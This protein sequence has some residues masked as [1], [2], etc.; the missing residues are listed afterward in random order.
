MKAK[1][2][3]TYVVIDV[4]IES[5]GRD[6]SP[7]NPLYFKVRDGDGYEYTGSLIGADNG[8]KSGELAQGERVR[9]TVSFDV[10]SEAKGLVVSYQPLVL[11]GGYQVIRVQLE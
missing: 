6:K 10:P 9:G 5:P 3:R 8:L 4:Q 11:F 7:Y 2:G 1:P